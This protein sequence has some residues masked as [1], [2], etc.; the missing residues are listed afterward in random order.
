MKKNN[1]T[2]H[3]PKSTAAADLTEKYNGLTKATYV[4]MMG[5]TDPKIQATGQFV[6]DNWETLSTTGGNS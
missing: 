3:N 5:S 2:I 6:I 1:W 4:T